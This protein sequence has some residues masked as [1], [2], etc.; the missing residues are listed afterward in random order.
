MKSEARNPKSESNPKPEIRNGPGCFGHSGFGIRI[1]FGHRHSDFGFH[2]LLVIGC[3][4][5]SFSAHAESFGDISAAPEAMY[6]GNTFHG[7]AEMRV[8]LENHSMSRAHNVTLVFP[9]QAWNN[10]NC[11]QRLSRTVTLA[12]GARAIVP[13]WQPPLP[14]NGDSSIRVEVDHR[15]AGN[16]RAPNADNHMSRYSR[17][18]APVLFISRGLDSEAV[19]HLFNANRSG[20]TAAMAIG[21]PDADN[22]GGNHLKTWVP[23]ERRY[24]K[25]NWLE[26]DYAPPQMVDK[27]SIYSTQAPSPLGSI[28]L[29]GTNGTN[30]AR[31][32]MSSARSS[33]SG[34]S[35]IADFSFPVTTAAVKT[36]RLNFDR[37]P[38]YSIGIDAV[39]ISGPAGSAWAA[40]ARASSDNSAQVSSYASG[41]SSPDV[42]ESLRAELPVAEWSENWLAYTPFDAIALNAADFNGMPS[43]VVAAV[44]NYLQAG[45]NVFVFGEGDLPATW[46]SAQTNTLPDG[47]EYHVGLGTCFVSTAKTVSTLDPKTLQFLRSAVNLAARYWQSLPDDANTANA[48]LPIVENLKVPVR[49]IVFIMLAFVVII[50]P[51]NIVVLNRRKHRTWML[52]TIPA[53]S[54]AITL[55]VFAYSLLREGITPDTRISGLTVLDQAA[56]HAATVGATA[57]YCPLTPNGGLRFD[58]ETEATPLVH[59]GYD[60]SGGSG[61]EV[62]WTQAQQYRRGWVTA[63]VP[64]YFHLRKSET[65]RER[66]QV[67]G[68]AGQW[69]AVNGLGAPIKSLWFADASGKIYRAENIAAGQKAGLAA[70]SGT[71]ISGGPGVEGLVHDVG[72]AAHTETLEASVKKYLL[73]GTLAA[74]LD[75]NPLVEFMDLMMYGFWGEG[76]TW[77]YEGNPFPSQLVAE[78]TWAAMFETQLQHWTKVPLATNTQPD[79]SNVGNAD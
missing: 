51:V 9:N 56:H 69:D 63:R 8:T 25:T 46:R 18:G 21:A 72:F 65:R 61:R 6:S 48:A 58:F 4:L 34:S 53:I 20:F 39:A 12:P 14:I 37:T 47:V 15:S 43:G 31:L 71:A 11:I 60:G 49:G 70:A 10:G 36:V 64:V 29:I 45:G 68:H 67:E 32:P 78:Q 13:L 33:S 55:V 52:W 35:W 1:S 17:G 59:M 75:G 73:P 74:E 41:A 50:G 26:L 28:V 30:V 54:F 57:F 42:T 3:L 16:I 79:F 76:H 40:D 5:F 23:D 24:G 66:L 62:D 44:G 7:Y 19:E 2:R 22:R 77:P 27:I 38:P